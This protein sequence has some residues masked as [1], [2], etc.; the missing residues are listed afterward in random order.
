MIRPRS[1][2]AGQTVTIRAQVAKLGG[3]EYKVEDW[4]IN[5]SGGRSWM[6]CEGN[7]AALTYAARGGF[8]GLPA[9]NEVLYGKVDGLGYLVHVSEIAVNEPEPAGPAGAR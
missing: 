7:P 5:V 4:W 3:K 2:L 8:A 1:P 6:V 9:D